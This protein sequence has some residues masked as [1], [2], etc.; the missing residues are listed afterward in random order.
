MFAQANGKLYFEVLKI[1][2]VPQN[3]LPPCYAS[4]EVRYSEVMRPLIKN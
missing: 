4:G 1:I 2:S 3:N